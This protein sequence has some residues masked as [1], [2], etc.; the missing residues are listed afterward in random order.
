MP[1]VSTLVTDA[2]PSLL[3]RFAGCCGASTLVDKGP[4]PEGT[5]LLPR[6]AC[7]ACA[8][9]KI[10]GCWATTRMFGAGGGGLYVVVWVAW[11]M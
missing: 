10:V 2:T 3:A 6:A 11:L 4:K 7:Y 1:A 9:K 5:A 8:L